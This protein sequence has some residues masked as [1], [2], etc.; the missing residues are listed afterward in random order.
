MR[1]RNVLATQDTLEAAA[2]ETVKVNLEYHIQVC[3]F[4]AFLLV[5]QAR[6]LAQN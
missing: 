2:Q 6:S 3:L 1:T 5:F 4:F